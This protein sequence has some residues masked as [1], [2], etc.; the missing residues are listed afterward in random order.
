MNNMETEK[1]NIYIV[2]NE[3][4]M[5]EILIKNT[6]TMIIILYISK[7]EDA[8]INIRR[9]Y[10]DI[11]RVLQNEIFLFVDVNEFKNTVGKYIKKIEIPL[12]EF[13][14][15]K[16]MI[17]YT[18]GF[19]KEMIIKS[20]FSLKTKLNELKQRLYN[21]GSMYNNN[22][23]D[24][25]E[26]NVNNENQNTNISDDIMLETNIQKGKSDNDDIYIKKI[27]SNTDANALARLHLCKPEND[28]SHTNHHFQP[29]NCNA[30]KDTAQRSGTIQ[31]F[32]GLHVPQ[33]EIKN[34]NNILQKMCMS[35]VELDTVNQIN[36][37]QGKMCAIIE[38]MKIN[39][40][41][42]NDLFD[43]SITIPH[44]IITEKINKMSGE[45]NENIS[46]NAK[47]V[48]IEDEQNNNDEKSELMDNLK[49]IYVLQQLQKIKEA[50]E[51]KK[52]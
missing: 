26:S 19:N 42:V 13:Y 41:N 37:K 50:E 14:F 38:S 31:Q 16:A 33:E 49:K 48:E 51:E 9:Q 30:F 25:R 28:D 20:I 36:T 4:D 32:V 46:N 8:Y 44:I 29:N 22:I 40:N 3:N 11:S 39:K 23:Y 10:I 24:S 47:I 5:D 45:K 52:K 1:S 34:G 43:S 18:S 17:A 27:I 21:S 2:L 15:N 7:K 12:I 35:G 6:N